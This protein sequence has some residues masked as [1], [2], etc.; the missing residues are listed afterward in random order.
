M[1]VIIAGYGRMGKEVET[2]CTQRNHTIV[3]KIDPVCGDAGTL[4]KELADR[5]DMVIEFAVPESAFDNLMLYT[6]FGINAVVGTTGWYDRI[7]EFKNLVEQ[8]NTGY[9]Y[10]S[11]FSIGAHLFFR[12]IARAAQGI[13]SFPEYDIMGFEIHHGKKKDSPSGTALSIA[14]IILENVNRK[15]TILTDK[16]DHVIKENELHF[17][18]LRG[19]SV[20]GI[21]KVIIDSEA[22]T[23]EI[24]HSARNRSGLAIGAVLASEWLKDKKGFFTIDDYISECL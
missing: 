12:L 6:K 16:C 19:G 21:H 22:D 23:I 17:A 9:L 10:G 14:K 18:S 2:I 5:A 13:N 15:D 4:T 8:G 20:P 3:A 11:N 24:S 1:K 7:D